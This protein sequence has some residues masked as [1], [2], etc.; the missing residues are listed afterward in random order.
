[1]D[2]STQK[3]EDRG[4]LLLRLEDEGTR[5]KVKGLRLEVAA[6]KK[7][8]KGRLQDWKPTPESDKIV[9]KGS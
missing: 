5:I 2:A 1:M 7:T 6:E 9:K 3:L 8:I 4:S